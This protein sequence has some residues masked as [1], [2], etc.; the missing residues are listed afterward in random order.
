MKVRKEE[1][2]TVKISFC[3]ICKQD[4]DSALAKMVEL[5]AQGFHVCGSTCWA[6]KK[7]EVT[8]VMKKR[9]IDDPKEGRK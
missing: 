2:V 7:D 8:V 5:K 9:T 1:N 3:M 4:L 6:A